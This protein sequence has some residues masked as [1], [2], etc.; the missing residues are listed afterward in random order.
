MSWSVDANILLYA[1]NRAAPEHGAAYRFLQ[2]RLGSDDPLFLCWEVMHAFLRISTS[3]GI[4][5]DPLSPIQAADWI[6][7]ILNLPGASTLSPTKESWLILKR[8]LQEIPV[9]GRLLT[10]AVIASQLEAAG[11]RNLYSAD[12]DFR[13]F[14]W[15]K[16]V[17]P[18]L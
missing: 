12:A 2:H 3:P 10:D 14:L 11:V 1:A 18:L 17:N 16:V 15:L 6:Q 5:P 4:F 7:S 8:E 9:R 13:K